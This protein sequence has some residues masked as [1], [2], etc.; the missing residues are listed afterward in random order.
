[1]AVPP[2]QLAIGEV[3]DK[4]LFGDRPYEKVMLD[5]RMVFLFEDLTMGALFGPEGSGAYVEYKYPEKYYE[6]SEDGKPAKVRKPL[7]KFQ[8]YSLQ[9]AN[10]EF[11][12]RYQALSTMGQAIPGAGEFLGRTQKT[13]L[14]AADF[15]MDRG[16]KEGISPLEY[17]AE[18]SGA[19]RLEN[20][21]TKEAAIERA[22]RDAVFR[23]LERLES[24]KK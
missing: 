6:A 12:K 21:P 10:A 9:V 1:M 24:G 22:K 16:A 23:Y 4:V 20:V 5:E 18:L 8:H 7:G 19:A 17:G 13:A 14:E 11:G 3:T 2:A 15:A